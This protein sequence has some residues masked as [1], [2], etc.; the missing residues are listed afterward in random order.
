M[1]TIMTSLFRSRETDAEA[2]AHK[3]PDMLLPVGLHTKSVSAL[4]FT[5]RIP[6]RQR[7][8]LTPP[9]P[10]CNRHLSAWFHLSELVFSCLILFVT[11]STRVCFMNLRPCQTALLLLFCRRRAQT[12][13]QT[14]YSTP[15]SFP[16]VPRHEYLDHLSGWGKQR[17]VNRLQVCGTSAI[18]KHYSQ[19]T[20]RNMSESLALCSREKVVL[21]LE[22]N[23]DISWSRG[24]C[25]TSRGSCPYEGNV[26]M[27]DGGWRFLKPTVKNV[28]L[29][30]E[31]M[32]AFPWTGGFFQ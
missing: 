2:L 18:L 1:S 6:K 25:Y 14:L 26:K 13:I 32:A 23:C 28:K 7:T 30:G 4:T 3:L 27:D 22:D 31:Q 20:Q 11:S 9:S 5:R 19:Q 17:C 12:A 8:T 24:L 21:T 16:A 29:S 15:V 10:R